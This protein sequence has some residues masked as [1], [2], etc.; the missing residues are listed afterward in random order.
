MTTT[1]FPGSA[2]A[3]GVEAGAGARTDQDGNEET[4][5]NDHDTFHDEKPPWELIEEPRADYR[6]T[7]R[8]KNLTFADATRL[9]VQL[10]AM[11][12]EVNEG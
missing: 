5:M 1:P 10:R 12:L 2:G 9:I 6:F 8:A 11:G 3:P 7:V 4:A